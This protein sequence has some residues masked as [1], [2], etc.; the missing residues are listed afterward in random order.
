MTVVRINGRKMNTSWKHIMVVKSCFL[1]EVSE[2]H[3]LKLKSMKTS[4]MQ[5]F[6]KRMKRGVKR[7]TRGDLEGNAGS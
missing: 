6:A 4:A 1:C 3:Q 7:K 5:N 2:L